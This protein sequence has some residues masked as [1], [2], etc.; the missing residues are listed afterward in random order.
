M[1]QKPH[2]K[3]RRPA[4]FSHTSFHAAAKLLHGKLHKPRSIRLF[5]APILLLLL[6]L[7]RL[8]AQF[9]QGVSMSRHPLPIPPDSCHIIGSDPLRPESWLLNSRSLCVSSGVC[10][11]TAEPKNLYFRIGNRPASQCAV[12]SSA[13]HFLGPAAVARALTQFGDCERLQRQLITC[14]HGEGL[15]MHNYTCPEER[16]ISHAI[17]AKEGDQVNWM[18]DV[19]ILVPE[20]PFPA[21]IFHY[22][23]VVTYVA[24]VAAHLDALL[25]DWGLQNVLESD[26]RLYFGP[27]ESGVPRSVNFLFKGQANRNLWQKGL[28]EAVLEVRVSQL[29]FNL[30]FEYLSDRDFSSASKYTC[31][32]NAIILGFRGHVNVWPFANDTAIPTDG[33]SVPVEALEVK[34]AVYRAAGLPG[35]DVRSG[36]SKAGRR[37]LRLPPLM[38]GYARRLG[39]EDTEAAPLGEN[40]PRGTL[41]RFSLEDERWFVGMLKN[42]TERAGVG[43]HVFTT[44]ATEEFE[45]QVRNIEKVGL[46][47]GIHGANLVNAMFMRPFGGLLELLPFGVMSRCYVAGSNSGLASWS[48]T[49]SAPAREGDG[50]PEMCDSRELVCRLK[51]RQRGV[52]LGT[53]GDR[54]KVAELVREAVEYLARLHAKFPDGVPVVLD[55]GSGRYVAEQANFVTF[56]ATTR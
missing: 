4:T 45:D 43:L 41:R 44:T 15:A 53:T 17:L 8:S 19:T 27:G 20:Y 50:G 56:A 6:L 54:E 13:L 10:L 36:E 28:L 12:S 24:F 39:T 5:L 46:V 40:V 31:L 18:E 9:S 26:G 21:N 52:F 32:R 29:G 37:R 47:V 14:A 51:F 2:V 34:E 7:S 16:S 55:E 1:P 42:E 11:S 3:P 23:N 38:V 33:S 35:L 48:F 25:S 30:R 22:A 49:A